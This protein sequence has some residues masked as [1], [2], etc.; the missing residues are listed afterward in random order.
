[1]S[2]NYVRKLGFIGLML[3]VYSHP[4]ASE[5]AIIIAAND[6]ELKWAPC[7][8]F[9]PA[10]C[11]I[12]VLHGDPAQPNVDILFKVPGNFTIPLHQH[13]S[14][15]RMILLSGELHVSYEGQPTATI[16]VGSYAYG[17][18]QL[19]HEAHCADGDDC[20]LFIAFEAP[21]DAIP[22]VKAGD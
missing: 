15:E 3:F 14:A 12:A 17:P 8:E 9:I 6:A 19:P 16:V 22:L 21:L 5:P 13:T 2:M 10:G 1:M 11:E 7:P 18:A 20:I 4:G